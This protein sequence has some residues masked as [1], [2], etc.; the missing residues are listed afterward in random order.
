[1]S[2]IL[3]RLAQRLALEPTLPPAQRLSRRDF[4]RLS[5]T[6]TAAT[7]LTS[8]APALVPTEAPRLVL[9]NWPEY[10]NP[11]NL[12]QF[13][14]NTGIFLDESTFDSNEALYEEVAN[15]SN[16]YDLI[17]PTDYIVPKLI[18]GKYLQALQH[19]QLP[20]LV[21]VLPRFREERAYDL[22]SRYSVTKNWGV[23]GIMWNADLVSEDI[24]SWADFWALA[25]KYSGRVALVEARDEILGAALKLLGYSYNETDVTHLEEAG[26]RL[27]EIRP[28]VSLVTDYFEGY[29]NKAIAMGIGWNGD[30]FIIRNTDGVA[31][32]YAIPLEGG[33]LWEDDWCIPS[34]AAH[35]LNAHKLINF[36][37]TPEVAAAEASFL[38]YATVVE[39]AL[40]LLDTTVRDDP[41]LYPPQ[42]VMETLE[43]MLPL[44]PEV[45]AARNKVWEEFV[46]GTSS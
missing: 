26:R 44:S 28:H 23:T 11:D 42:A 12:R 5:A 14:T 10:T 17:V 25:P 2:R 22:G 3:R 43:Q 40:P 4:L 37:L 30:A 13:T 24:S 15:G 21:E 35:P 34:N 8:C 39:K 31:M 1:M 46:A 41:T 32:R 36:I 7:A 45:E 9:H 27:T 38:G 18:A 20:N 33:L 29:G 6:L 16:A 19:N